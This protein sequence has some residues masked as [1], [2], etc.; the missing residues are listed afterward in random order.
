M[1][2]A[3]TLSIIVPTYNRRTILTYSV[4]SILNQTVPP[5]EVIIVDDGS[6]DGTAEEVDKRLK[7]DPIWR[8]RVRFIYQEN[9]G[10]GAANNT[11]IR[12]ASGEWIGF[13]ASDDIWLPNKLEMQLEA[14]HKFGDEY[15]LCFSDAWFMNNPYMK[16]TVFEASGTKLTQMFG[17]VRDASHLV[18]SGRHPVWMQT[19]LIRA[20]IVRK[21]GGVDRE[22]RYSEDHDFMFRSSLHTKFC[23]VA[24]PLV[25][26]DRSP[27][28]TRHSGVAT[29]WH[30]EEFCLR[31]EQLR[32]EKQLQ[33]SK[34]LSPETKELGR[35][36]LCHVHQSWSN[37][38]L[39]QGNYDQARKSLAT[40][41]EYG[42]PRKQ[43]MKW[44]ALKFAPSIL[45]DAV[46]RDGENAVRYD[47]ASW[48]ADTSAGTI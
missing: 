29:D 6:T 26:I 42:R 24:L 15:G 36:H 5:H 28:Q 17:V 20:D 47:R 11:G 10:Q 16:H 45:R 25:L 2:T 46:V 44:L 12:M 39:K 27:A 43:M 21:V 7:N 1:A 4:D 14:L 37:L 41:S 32:F 33:L 23:F 9:Q 3:R 18:G 34:D 30:K 48:L 31:M 19:A 22:L 8:E 35:Q 13:N 38:Y 40:A